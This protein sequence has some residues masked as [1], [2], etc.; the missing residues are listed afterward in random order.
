MLICLL[1][2]GLHN[3]YDPILKMYPILNLLILQNPHRIEG[4]V[5][6]LLHAHDTILFRQ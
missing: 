5:R 2:E 6:L 1:K 4:R 3:L